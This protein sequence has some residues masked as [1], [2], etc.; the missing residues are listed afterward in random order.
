MYVDTH[1]SATHLT[2]RIQNIVK[3]LINFKQR[4]TQR[5]VSFRTYSKQP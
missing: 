1:V 3:L 5:G 4:H 2:D